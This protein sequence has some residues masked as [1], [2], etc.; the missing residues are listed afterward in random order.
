[1]I[2]DLNLEKEFFLQ[3]L[4]SSA[5]KNICKGKGGQTQWRKLIGITNRDKKGNL[6]TLN[7]NNLSYLQNIVDYFNMSEGQQELLNM[8]IDIPE[9]VDDLIDMI[10]NAK[11][12]DQM[13]DWIVT[14]LFKKFRKILKI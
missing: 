12:Y 7:K 6:I 1:M 3:Q 14:E 11:T 5:Y 8:G 2:E 9:H 4:R 10:S 13:R